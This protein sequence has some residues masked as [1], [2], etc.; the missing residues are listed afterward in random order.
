[1]TVAWSFSSREMYNTCPKQYQ[2][3][4]VLKNF[5]DDP[6]T[7]WRIWGNRV[8]KAME[9]ALR[10]GTPLPEGMTMWQNIA[11]Q[12]RALKG[13]LY[14]EQQLAID[15]AFQPCDW[16]SKTTWCRFIV[17]AMWIDGDVAKAIDWKTGKPKVG[18]DQLALMALGILHHHPQV[19]EVR[20]RFVWLKNGTT[21]KTETFKR[22]QMP[23]LWQIFLTD[24]KR[25]ESSLATN[26][27]VPKTSGLC[28]Q[29]CPVVTC[30][31]NGKRRNW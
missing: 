15:E 18:S 26:T 17:D 14:T 8:H 27:W 11:D 20:T 6:N 16:F 3:V 25:L 12:F 28:S 13:T 19:Q 31:F 24:I 21:S 4:R 10:D 7:E 5:V 30:Q 29:W 22:E 23:Q 2:E 9:L 1:M